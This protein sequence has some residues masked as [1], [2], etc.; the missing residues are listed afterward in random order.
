MR[1]PLSLTPS[2]SQSAAAAAIRAA[3]A[4]EEDRQIT[5][6]LLVLLTSS[7]LT[8]YDSVF[9]THT[10]TPSLAARLSHRHSQDISRVFLGSCDRE[11][12]RVRRRT[13]AGSHDV[14]RGCASPA[15]TVSLSPASSSSLVSSCIECP[16]CSAVS[17]FR[18]LLSSIFYSRSQRQADRHGMH[19][20][21][22]F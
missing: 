8:L 22:T 15:A 14:G 5:R 4:A 11:E 3:T 17:A 12:A 21:F 10:L 20:F 16:Q 1:L 6:S 18:S 9:H 7:V 19:I 2:V 13:D